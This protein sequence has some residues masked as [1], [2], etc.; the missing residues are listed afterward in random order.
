MI[1][2]AASKDIHRISAIHY[3]SPRSGSKD[4][5]TYKTAQ[6]AANYNMYGNHFEE[7]LSEY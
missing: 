3:R 7:E 5:A 2:V 6:I 4:P 1:L